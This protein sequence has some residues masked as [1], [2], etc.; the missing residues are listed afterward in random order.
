ML[1]GSGNSNQEKDYSM[2]DPNRVEKITYYRLSQT[3]YDGNSETFDPKSVN[4]GA[5]QHVNTMI[6][7]SP[8]PFYNELRIS[9]ESH[10]DQLADLQIYDQS[11]NMVVNYHLTIT[12][13]YNSLLIPKA[14]RLSPGLYYLNF[15]MKD[16]QPLIQKV[17]KE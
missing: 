2:I 10:S 16:E 7:L 9:C 1:D 3:D 4:P 11:G 13:G 12:T 15:S 5:I 8:N 17:I 6:T 14:E